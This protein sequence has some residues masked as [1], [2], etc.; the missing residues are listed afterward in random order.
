MR[1]IGIFGVGGSNKTPFNTPNEF[2]ENE[3]ETFILQGYN[4]ALLQ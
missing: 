3:L 2:D 1:N 4:N